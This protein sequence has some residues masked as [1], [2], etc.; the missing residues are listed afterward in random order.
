MLS[1]P[2]SNSQGAFSYT[3]S[4]PAVATVSGSIVSIVGPGTATITATQA[5]SGGHAAAS[6]SAVLT[7][8]KR[9]EPAV[10]TYKIGDRGPASGWVFYDK[11]TTS[12]GWR[13][14]EAAPMDQTWFFGIPWNNGKYINIRTDT[15]VGAGK[16]NTDAIVAA[17]GSGSYAAKLCQDLVLGGFDDWFLPSADEL[18]LMYEN[19]KKAGLGGFSAIWHWSSSQDNGSN[20]WMQRCADGFRYNLSTSSNGSVR[21]V[22]GF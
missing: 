7:V 2:T 4:D 18:N 8:D 22:R 17:Q 14:L 16:K 5:A 20:A 21:A 1:P 15:A 3:S 12:D 19:L 6:I 11:G 13:Y 10:K 9:P